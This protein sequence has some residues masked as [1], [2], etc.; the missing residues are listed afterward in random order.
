MLSHLIP[1]VL[2]SRPFASRGCEPDVRRQLPGKNPAGAAPAG[3]AGEREKSGIAVETA[4]GDGSGRPPHAPETAGRHQAERGGAERQPVQPPAPTRRDAH[5]RQSHQDPFPGNALR[6]PDRAIDEPQIEDV[7]P[8]RAGS[9]RPHRK[10]VVVDDGKLDGK[11]ARPAAALQHGMNDPGALP[12][13]NVAHVGLEKNV[14]AGLWPHRRAARSLGRAYLIRARPALTGPR[15]SLRT[16]SRDPIRFPCGPTVWRQRCMSSEVTTSRIYA[17]RQQ[18]RSNV[19]RAR[20]INMT[21]NRD[22]A[23][24]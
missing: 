15:S 1:K 21:S 5:Q 4:Q 2:C 17:T 18:R 13:G 9:A 22:A 12:I 14:L 23:T 11:H 24:R 10:V 16:S 7:V 20:Y 3:S 19:L 8:R 6:C